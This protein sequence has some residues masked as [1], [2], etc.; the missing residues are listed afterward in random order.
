MTSEADQRKYGLVTPEPLPEKE[1][2][3]AKKPTQFMSNSWCILHELATRCDK[4][5]VHQ[6]L[7]AGR[8][9]KAA[10]YPDEL[11]RAICRGLTNQK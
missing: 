10:E 9:S 7:M 3:T 8:A 4:S 6:E 11:C 1:L 2:M 5:H